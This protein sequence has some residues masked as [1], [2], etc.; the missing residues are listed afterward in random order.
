MS[1]LAALYLPELMFGKFGHLKDRSQ[2]FLAQSDPEESVNLQ[3]IKNRIHS[4]IFCCYVQDS[5]NM[6]SWR[7]GEINFQ[8][9]FE[10]RLLDLIERLT[11]RS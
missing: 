8:V 10:L 11:A 7:L 6:T 9:F 2:S 1:K 3:S 5:G 4:M